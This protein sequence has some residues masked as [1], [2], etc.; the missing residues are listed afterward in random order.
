MVVEDGMGKW[1]VLDNG[2]GWGCV[3]DHI[4]RK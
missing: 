3:D 1:V 4:E 2:K